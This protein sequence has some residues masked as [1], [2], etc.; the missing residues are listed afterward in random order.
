MS[1]D[2]MLERQK[3]VLDLPKTKEGLFLHLGCGPNVFEGF[4][5]VDKFVQKPGIKSWDIG[6]IP[7][8]ENSVDSI[9]SSHSLEH[10]NIRDGIKALRNWYKILREG[11][12]LYLAVPDLREICKKMATDSKENVQSWWIYTLFGY[13][14]PTES[15]GLDVPDEPGQYHMSGY[16]GET[17]KHELIGAGFDEINMFGYDGYGTPSI[18]CEA[19]K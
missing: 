4:V 16:T 13:Q 14:A 17:L 15:K 18:W 19:V 5:N 7:L 8:P 12:T 11:G 1:L 10:L 2:K 3:F 6:K 9:Y